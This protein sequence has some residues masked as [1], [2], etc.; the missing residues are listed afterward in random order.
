VL[1]HG[2]SGE[3][4]EEAKKK[5]SKEAKKERSREADEQKVP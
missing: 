3:E 1:G 4:A 5:R 2:D